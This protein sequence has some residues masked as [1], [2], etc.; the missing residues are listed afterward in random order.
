[1]ENRTIYNNFSITGIN[2]TNTQEYVEAIV[3][4]NTVTPHEIKTDSNEI[5]SM[6]NSDEELNFKVFG[7]I[8]N[9]NEKVSGFA[10]LS[11]LNDSK[12]VLIEYIAIDSSIRNNVSFLSYLDL[13]KSYIIGLSLDVAYW[14][15]EISN[16]GDGKNVDKESRLFRKLLYLENFG[17]LKAPYHTLQIGTDNFEST[18]EAKL[19]IQTDDAI[20]MLS[21]K[22]YIQ[23]VESIYA[24][25]KRWFEIYNGDSLSN[26]YKEKANKNL[27]DIQKITKSDSEIAIE[28]SNYGSLKNMD[29]RENTSKLLPSEENIS[30]KKIVI[31]AS[32]GLIVGIALI[33][34]ANKILNHFGIK[35]SEVSST[36]GS[37]IAV[38]FTPIVGVFIGK[39]RKNS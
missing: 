18:F 9:Y 39:H 3:I 6:L 37:I 13:L 25:S 10:M 19:Y 29:Y 16:K 28:Y 2:K 38:V 22:T 4:Y 31:F 15:V 30:N 8:L 26:K 27:T 12:S 35:I 21:K 17:E 7:F 24:Y 33:L 11:Y 1:M 5:T 23:I 14:I 32:F 36:L 34:I 20:P